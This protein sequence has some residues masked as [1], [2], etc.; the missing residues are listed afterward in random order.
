MRCWR[1]SSLS[2]GRTLRNRQASY[3]NVRFFELGVCVIINGK[4]G[5]FEKVA[6]AL[7]KVFA[8]EFIR[9]GQAKY[10]VASTTLLYFTY[11]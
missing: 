10:Y 6:G 5:F 9:T 8:Y 2:P 7:D 11:I 4:L 3:L 1:G